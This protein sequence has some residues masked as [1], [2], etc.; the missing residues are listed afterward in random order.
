MNQHQQTREKLAALVAGLLAPREASRVQ[1]H[2]AVCPE[3]R[4]EEEVWRRLL[5]AMQRVPETLPTPAR[6]AHIAAR[7]EAH[8]QEVLEQRWNRLVLTGLVLYGWALFVVVLPVLPLGVSWLAEHFSLHW[9]VVVIL[10]LGLWWSFCWVIGLSLL[11]VL[12]AQR[13]QLEE[14]TL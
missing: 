12:R 4:R 6:L 2:L 3:C 5:R 11:P 7:A 13:R 14:K 1:D 10:G 8:R 9:F